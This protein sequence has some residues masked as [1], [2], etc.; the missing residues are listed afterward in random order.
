MATIT[1]KW[2][3]LWLAASVVFGSVAQANQSPD[4]ESVAGIEL[5]NNNQIPLLDNRF[6]ID[7]EVEEVTLLFFREPGSPPVILVRPDGSKMYASMAV[8]GEAEWFDEATYDLIRIV[9]PM[10]GPWQAVG[11][12]AEGSKVLIIT[13]FQLEVED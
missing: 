12:L 8:T 7:S 2:H 11:Q 1:V 3:W 9:E 5:Y 4:P 10:P 6:R 13:D